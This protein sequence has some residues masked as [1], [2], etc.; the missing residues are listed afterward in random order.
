MLS[1]CQSVE[2]PKDM[3]SV[4]DQSE[5]IPNSKRTWDTAIGGFRGTWIL[6]PAQHKREAV[7]GE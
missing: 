6:Y 1:N 5:E 3:P 2:D 7:S 4:G